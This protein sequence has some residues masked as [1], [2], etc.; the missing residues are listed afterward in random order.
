MVNTQFDNKMKINCTTAA[1]RVY[2]YNPR[3]D[4][5]FLF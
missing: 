5:Y 3:S 4:I 2:I 1:M